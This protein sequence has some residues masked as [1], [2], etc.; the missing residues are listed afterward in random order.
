MKRCAAFFHRGAAGERDALS[1]LRMAWRD[2]GG[3]GQRLE[4]VESRAQIF[5]RDLSPRN[6]FH[7]K[8]QRKRKSEGRKEGARQT[9]SLSLSVEADSKASL[10]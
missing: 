9:A 7:A 3:A 6:G 8:T 10:R 5:L 4:V 1:D 2:V